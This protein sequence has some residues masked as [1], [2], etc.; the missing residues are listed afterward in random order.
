M[1]SPSN[2]NLIA[3]EQGVPEW[4]YDDARKVSEIPSHLPLE[5]LVLLKFAGGEPLIMNE[6][7]QILERL[8]Q[9]PKLTV[10]ILTNL[11]KLSD[12]ALSA[13]AKAKVKRLHLQVSVDGTGDTY[14]Y[15]RTG[16]RWTDLTQNLRKL[17]SFSAK[18]EITLGITFVAQMWNAFNISEFL[19][20]FLKIDKEIIKNPYSYYPKIHILHV[21]QPFLKLGNLTLS[22]LNDVKNDLNQLFKEQSEEHKALIYKPLVAFL[23]ESTNKQLAEFS[24]FT[25]QL[26][27]KRGTQLESL[28]PKFGKYLNQPYD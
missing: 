5:K 16:G 2:S 25:K 15:I 1:C 3:K 4:H 11:S 24:R 12:R 20:W 10:V 27:E 28:S 21:L 7:L 17:R 23:E 8:E 22:D 14:E 9:L 13:L 6:A 26:D 19:L 18:S